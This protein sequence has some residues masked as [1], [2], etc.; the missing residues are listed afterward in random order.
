MRL[1]SAAI[2]STLF[3][4]SS[5]QAQTDAR[6]WQ[7]G[8]VLVANLTGHGPSDAGAKKAARRGDVWWTYCLSANGWAYTAVSREGP[9]KTGLEVN[10]T[11]RFSIAKNR[12]TVLNSKKERFI[13]RI[14]R[15]NNRNTCSQE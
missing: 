14:T 3:L 7:Q 11:I 2:L 1:L 12:M 6:R 4:F 13:L 9:A 15:Q 5:L 8:R 10:S